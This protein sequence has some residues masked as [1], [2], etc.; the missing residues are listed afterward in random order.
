M[1]ESVP[2]KAH[3]SVCLAFVRLHVMPNESVQDR[4]GEGRRPASLELTQPR[5]EEGPK[6]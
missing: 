5:R 1:R 4:G 6:P 3:R 2:H